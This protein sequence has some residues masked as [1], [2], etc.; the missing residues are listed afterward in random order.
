[1]GDVLKK[2][3]YISAATRNSSLI[4]NNVY[5]NRYLKIIMFN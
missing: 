2:K 3:V 1:M 5:R 4:L